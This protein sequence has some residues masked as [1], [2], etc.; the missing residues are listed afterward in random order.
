M[1]R[2]DETAS[3]QAHDEALDRLILT[4]EH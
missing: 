4:A 2:F 3:A 1:Q